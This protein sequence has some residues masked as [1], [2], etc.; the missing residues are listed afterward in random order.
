[1]N[2]DHRRDHH[3]RDRLEQ[4]READVCLEGMTNWSSGE[5]L[6]KFNCRAS[7]ASSDIPLIY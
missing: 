1:M 4:V 6:K 7:A 5:N 2:N 3:H